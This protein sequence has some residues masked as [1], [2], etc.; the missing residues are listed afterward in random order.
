MTSPQPAIRRMR[1]DTYL[2]DNTTHWF[3]FA[4]SATSCPVF[5]GDTRVTM[6]AVPPLAKPIPKPL[7][8]AELDR[9]APAFL[10]RLLDFGDLPPMVDRLRVPVV[11]TAEKEAAIEAQSP[12][13]AFL[14]SKCEVEPGAKTPKADVYEAYR[15]WCIE[16]GGE[17]ILSPVWFG[18]E[19]WMQPA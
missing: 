8:I 1:T 17:E 12:V 10:R 7:L 13:V 4:N 19:C 18:R 14:R 11:N 2:I 9:E 6:L 3:H 15:A 16:S 5:P